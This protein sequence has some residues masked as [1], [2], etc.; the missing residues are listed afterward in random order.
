MVVPYINMRSPT[1]WA[2]TLKASAQASIVP[3]MTGMPAGNPAAAAA[4]E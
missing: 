3:V 2:P 4:S 1:P